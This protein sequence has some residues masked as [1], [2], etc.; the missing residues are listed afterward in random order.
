M[1]KQFTQIMDGLTPEETELLLSGVEEQCDEVT[2]KR[3]FRAVSK[4]IKSERKQ[5]RRGVSKKALAWIVAAAVLLAALG[6]GS[7]AFA[8]EAA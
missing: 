2:N 8:A 6:V 1:N 7:Y 4:R 3:L 5:A